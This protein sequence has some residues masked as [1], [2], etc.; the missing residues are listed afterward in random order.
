YRLRLSDYTHHRQAASGNRSWRLGGA[1]G[2][3]RRFLGVDLRRRL[4]VGV[5]VVRGAL[6]QVA[7]AGVEDRPV[8]R[9]LAV[10]AAVAPDD[11]VLRTWHMQA[12]RRVPDHDVLLV[13]V[14]QLRIQLVV[15]GEEI[16]TEPDVHLL[17]AVMPGDPEI[18]QGESLV[19]EAGVASDALR[20]GNEVVTDR[21]RGRRVGFD[22]L[23]LQLQLRVRIRHRRRGRV[24]DRVIRIG[25]ADAREFLRIPV[26]EALARDFLG[27]DLAGGVALFL[28]IGG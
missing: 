9:G 7:R 18:V 3:R 20:V 11:A 15:L 26:H 8:D 27:N 4:F 25:D 17:R 19:L 23:R 24:H 6:E 28:G 5:A 10:V 1:F 21:Q 12:G 2:G 13:E 16:I 14:G 22:L